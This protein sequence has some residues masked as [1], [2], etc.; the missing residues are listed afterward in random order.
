MLVHYLFSSFSALSTWADMHWSL[1]ILGSQTQ[2]RPSGR[3]NTRFSLCWTSSGRFRLTMPPS[4][5]QQARFVFSPEIA[6]QVND[7]L[8]LYPGRCSVND[9]HNIYPAFQYRGILDIRK[10]IQLLLS[11]IW[12]GKAK[13]ACICREYWLEDLPILELR[14]TI[15]LFLQV[16]DRKFRWIQTNRGHPKTYAAWTNK[17]IYRLAYSKV[18]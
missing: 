17:H 7:L 18:L 3:N 5:I 8:S 2:S 10:L 9:G 14:F 1:L 15:W 16:R 4:G 12:E 11:G 13:L 6:A